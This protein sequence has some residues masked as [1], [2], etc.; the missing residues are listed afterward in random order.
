MG[1]ETRGKNVV[2]T[3]GHAVVVSD[4]ADSLI[5]GR[6]FNWLVNRYPISV[7]EIWEVIDYYAEKVPAT[8]KNFQ[9]HNLGSDTDVD[10]EVSKV[11]DSVY[12]G[13]IAFGKVFLPESQDL[14]VLFTK[15]LEMIIIEVCNE[16]LDNGDIDDTS[17]LHSVVYNELTN[18]IGQFDPSTI[19]S[20]MPITFDDE[21]ND[22]GILH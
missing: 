2:V 7:T 5:D 14:R 13:L 1:L 20:S 3:S 4:I 22:K 11:S 17:N 10:L 9:L 15:G 16:L 21:E 6:D 8:D 18:V 12:F 19:L